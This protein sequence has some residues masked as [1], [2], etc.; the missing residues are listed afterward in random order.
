MML[1]LLMLVTGVD[2]QKIDRQLTDLVAPTANSSTRAA[3]PVDLRAVKKR[4]AISLNPD[5]TLRSLSAI[6][7]LKPGAECPTAL[8]EQMGIEVRFVLGDMVALNIPADKLLS[9]NDV[10][11]FS[12]IQADQMA[13]LMNEEARKATDVEKVN[14]D[15]A[16]KAASLPKAFTGANVVLGVIDIGID[17]NHA[18]FRNAD[19]TSRIKMVIDYASG[20]P[21]VCKT[22]AE[23][24]ALTADSKMES[25][26]THTSSIAGGSDV[27][28][29][30]QGVAPQADLVL[31]GLGGNLSATNVISCMKQ[32]FEYAQSVG[33]PAVISLSVGEQLGFHDGGNVYC[34]AVETLTENGT[35]KGRAVVICTGNGASNDL[36]VVKELHASETVVDDWQFGTVLGAGQLLTELDPTAP[37]LYNS[38]YY[39]YVSDYSDFDIQLKV[40]D[41]TNG[42]LSAFGTDV[43]DI[44]GTPVKE[45]DILV[46]YKEKTATGADGT[47]WRMNCQLSSIKLKNI[48]KRLA[49]FVKS[50]KDGQKITLLCDGDSSKE[51]CFDAPTTGGYDFAKAKYTKGNGILSCNASVC[52][53]HAISVGAYI[54][55][56]E[57]TNYLKAEKAYGPSTLTGQVQK[58]GEISDFSSWGI[59]DNGKNYPTIVSPGQ[60]LIAGGNNY[61]EN[62]F[63]AG[64]PG[65]VSTE[66]THDELCE[67]VDK[68]GRANWYLIDQG[69]S[70]STPFAAGII[71]LW[72]QANPQLTVND[73]LSILKEKSVNDEFTTDVS[74]IPSG[75]K[76]Q[77]GYG[78][79]NCLA[80]LQ[81]ILNITGIETIGADGRRE[82]TPATMYSVDAPVYNMMGQRVGKSQK[83]LVIYKGRKYL[84]K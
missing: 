36:S 69:T 51:P 38:N 58:V 8:L 75:N 42:Q 9:L 3:K 65:V 30:Q 80:G 52:C 22:D 81:K 40:V 64:Q 59:D 60:G 71:T 70:M 43:V 23:I 50:K 39:F 13:R 82:A 48:N 57:W 34:K 72:M 76:V 2:A 24:R 25:H 66:S 35:A 19:G 61:D 17:Y 6:A 16:A 53:D 73:I 49:L 12:Y 79:I 55:R 4:L 26:G 10:E 63:A 37:V 68:N 33:K 78:K 11:A 56:A 1:F 84:N 41:L 44:I 14:T 77:A 32:I 46:K 29:R 27:G 54:T 21:V 74:K 7:T 47:C 31:C 18:A 28:N 83:G 62:I 45:S 20:T 67:K 5:G 15:A